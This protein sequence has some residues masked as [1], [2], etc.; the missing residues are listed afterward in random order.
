MSS[1]IRQSKRMSLSIALG[2]RRSRLAESQLLH[3][4][5]GRAE[6]DR[7]ALLDQRMPQGASK[8]GL[9]A[10]GLCPRPRY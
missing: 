6:Q 10:E 1:K 7:A 2:S 9:A 4:L 5:I 3:E 8:M